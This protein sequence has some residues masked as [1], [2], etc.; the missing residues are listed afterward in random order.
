LDWKLRHKT[1][2]SPELWFNENNGGG[3]GGDVNMENDMVVQN[4]AV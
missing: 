2:C 1:E 3:A 4:A